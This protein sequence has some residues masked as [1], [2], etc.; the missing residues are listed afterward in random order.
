MSK[1][2]NVTTPIIARGEHVV[3]RKYLASDIDTYVR[4]IS[5]G[6]WRYF[7]APWCGYRTETTPEQEIKDR[8]WFMKEL[9]GDSESYLNRRAVITIL[10]GIPIGDVSRYSDKQNPYYWCVGIGICEDDYL[11]QGLGTEALRLWIDYLFTISNIHKFCLE[12]WSFNPRMMRSAEKAGFIL[13]GRQREMRLW[14][15]EWLDFMLFGIVREEWESRGAVS[16]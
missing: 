8:E 16:S 15:D 13:E 12:T 9:N 3:L 7:N 11:N 6:E 2:N 1:D 5:Q 14:Q 4:W 10:D